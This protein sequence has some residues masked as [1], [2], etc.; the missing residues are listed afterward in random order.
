M[1]HEE[2]IQFLRKVCAERIQSIAAAQAPATAEA[3]AHRCEMA[4]AALSL[5]SILDEQEKNHAITVPGGT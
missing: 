5:A 2:A 1:T 3:L 4:F